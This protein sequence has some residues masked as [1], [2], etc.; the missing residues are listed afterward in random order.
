MPGTIELPLLPEQAVTLGPRLAVIE[1]P[2]E[3]VFV[4]LRRGAPECATG[5]DRNAAR[6]PRRSVA[7]IVSAVSGFVANGHQT[8]SS[9]FHKPPYDPGRPDFPGPVLTL[10]NLWSPSD[11]PGSSSADPHTPPTPS[12]TPKVAP[13]VPRPYY[14]R[15]LMRRSGAQSPFA[16]SGCY[17]SLSRSNQPRRQALPRLHRYYE[18]MRQ[19]ST[20]SRPQ[21]VS[22]VPRV[23]AGCCQPRLGRGPSRRYRCE[24]FLT[25]LDPY[26]GC[27]CGAL[28]RF[29]P[30]DIGLPRDVI[31]SALSRVSTL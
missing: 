5:R 16:H 22:L 21:F 8:L 15:V 14:V 24:S 12:F 9:R 2:K 25:C 4:R 17:P 28:A 13:Y 1:T 27:S 10:T 11:D 31:R 19:S 26:P 3:L 30:Q 29:F 18:L 7:S 23:F 20:L 6:A